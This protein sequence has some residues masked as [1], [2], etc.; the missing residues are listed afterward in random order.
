MVAKIHERVAELAAPLAKKL[1]LELVD[2]EY[3]KEGSQMVLRVYIDRDGGIRL[4]DCE[5][6][7]RVLSDEL[8]RVDPIEESYLL[9]IS[10]PG[11][12]RP[13]KKELDFIRFAGS[14]AQV[15]LY[16]P[17]NGQKSFTGTLRGFENEE[18]LLEDEA[19]KLIRIP[20][21]KVAKANLAFR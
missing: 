13:L 2:I 15:K 9:E 21:S 7:N 6:L 18:I 3:V 16:S 8:D 11:I 17:L 4:E 14:A 19:K 20:F 10:S 5:A 12:E 1:N